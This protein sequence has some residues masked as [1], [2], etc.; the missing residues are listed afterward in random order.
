MK[1]VLT[2]T[3]QD[4]CIDYLKVAPVDRLAD[5]PAGRRPTDLLPQAKSVIVLGINISQGVVLANK[6]AYQG[7]RHSIYTYLWYGYGLLN[8]HFLDKATLRLTKTLEGMGYVAYPISAGAVEDL[9][10]PA[11]QFP[12]REAAVAAGLGEIGYNGQLLTPGAGP[13]VRYTSVITTAEIDP[14]DVYSGPPLCDPE[15]C[16]KGT[17]SGLP[18]CVDICPVGALEPHVDERVAAGNREY[19]VARTDRFKCMWANFGLHKGSLALRE[20]DMP[21]HQLTLEDVVEGLRK[22]AP[23]QAAELMVL[24][25]ANYCDR[26]IVEC[27]APLI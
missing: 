15:R 13:R 11:G 22:A 7:V 3:V 16:A 12:N 10:I 9:S 19:R 18:V 14:D 27:P 21:Q 26:C 25:R 1:G 17:S 5:L 23:V 20:V 2:R 8:L 4:D 24:K 6:R